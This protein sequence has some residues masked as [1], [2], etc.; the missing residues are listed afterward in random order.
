[1]ASFDKKLKKLAVKSKLKPPVLLPGEL[2]QSQ[3]RLDWPP[4]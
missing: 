2:W 3:A 4:G 1:M